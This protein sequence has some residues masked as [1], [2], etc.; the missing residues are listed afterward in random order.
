MGVAMKRLEGEVLI[1]GG[2]G[3]LGRAILRRARDEEWPAKITVVSRD[4][5]KHHA[6][7]DE[8]PGGQWVV[9]DVCDSIE[10][11]GLILGKKVVI[12]AAAL[13]HIPEAELAP[14]P[15]IR[16]NVLGSPTLPPPGKTA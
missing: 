6:A 3:L 5:Q 2:A 14:T 16:L 4:P 15:S 11:E 10:M 7:A 9:G 1:T 8:F 13:K 12:H